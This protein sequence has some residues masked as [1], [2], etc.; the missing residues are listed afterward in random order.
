MSDIK[1]VTQRR[2]ITFRVTERLDAALKRAAAAEHNKPSAVIR[3]LLGAG[4]ARERRR[5][6]PKKILTTTKETQ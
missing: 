5:S 6:V 2:R 1:P 3:R 4:L